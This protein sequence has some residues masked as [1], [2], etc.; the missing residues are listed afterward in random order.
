MGRTKRK[1]SLQCDAS[2][3]TEGGL[4]GRVTRMASES[5]V[6]LAWVCGEHCQA[7]LSCCILSPFTPEN[8]YRLLSFGQQAFGKVYFGGQDVCPPIHT[9]LLLLCVRDIMCRMSCVP[10]IWK[11]DLFQMCVLRCQ[12][13][14]KRGTFFPNVYIFNLILT[15][16]HWR[17]NNLP[18]EIATKGLCVCVS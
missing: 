11:C 6:S 9:D 15:Y 14:C 2:S 3:A 17:W 13:L 1:L 5:L 10:S 8:E 7:T 4:Q 12:V 16:L 18:V